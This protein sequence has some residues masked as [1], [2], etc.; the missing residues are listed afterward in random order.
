MTHYLKA[1]WARIFCLFRAHRHPALDERLRDLEAESDRE[2]AAARRM[3]D[4]LLERFGFAPAQPKRGSS[5]RL[6]TA[7]AQN[8]C[9]RTTQA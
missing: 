7:Q 1:L 6:R 3:Q 5:G 2:F 8:L 4:E 9:G